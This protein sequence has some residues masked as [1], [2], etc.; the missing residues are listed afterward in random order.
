MHVFVT[1]ATGWVGSVVVRDLIEAGHRVTG[2]S[3]SADK[4]EALAAVGGTVL[5]GTLDD[6]D[7]LGR[8]AAKADAV[9]H[10]AFNHNFSKFAE[11]C[12]QDRR[13]IEA[14]GGALV[15]SERPLIV[16]SGMAMLAK[17][18][19][20]TEADV[21]PSG[22]SYPRQ[23]EAAAA[24]LRE[25]GVRAA[26]V[27][28]APSVHGIGD[29]GFVPIL[30]AKARETGVSAYIGDGANRW[31]AVHRLDA[32]RLYRLVLEEGVTRPAYHAC[33]EEGIAFKDIAAAIG[34]GLGVPVER[35]E[36]EH[37]GWFAGFAGADMA[38][39]SEMTREWLGWR[40]EGPELLADLAQ[41]GYYQG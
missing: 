2:L 7:L 6:L 36:A 13:A 23:S 12:E 19:P 30:I 28:L 35:R 3:R 20:A 21:P 8:A 15:G 39:S 40:P 16:T 25:R 37:F 32:G 5:S 29:H 4:A 11:N 9:I 26:S 31:P 24:A 17:G 33:A 1:G 34:R 14:L 22:P 41:P 10:T 38:A 18:R 27:R